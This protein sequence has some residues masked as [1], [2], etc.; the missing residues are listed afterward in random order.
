MLVLYF[1]EKEQGEKEQGEK[2]QSALGLVISKRHYGDSRIGRLLE[3]VR[4]GEF[5]QRMQTIGGYKT[6]KSGEVVA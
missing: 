1:V 6:G 4:S 5:Q 3:V 2:E